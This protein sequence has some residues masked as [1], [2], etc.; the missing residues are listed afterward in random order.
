MK[1]SSFFFTE[2]QCFELFSKITFL[3]RAWARKN[4]FEGIVKKCSSGRSF[5]DHSRQFWAKNKLTRFFAKVPKM[6]NPGLEKC[7]TAFTCRV[8]NFSKKIH[9][10][11][12]GNAC[13]SLFLAVSCKKKKS[14]I[15]PPG[16]FSPYCSIFRGVYVAAQHFFLYIY[17]DLNQLLM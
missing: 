1:K 5:W 15:K 17:I 6:P 3:T 10:I 16:A 8:W 13:S 4:F 9:V 14:S 12:R 7:T 2:K 11:R